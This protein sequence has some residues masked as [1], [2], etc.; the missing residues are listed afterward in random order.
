M[1]FTD[2]EKYSALR[3]KQ[4][5]VLGHNFTVLY[6]TEHKYFDKVYLFWDG[7]KEHYH[8]IHNVNS[9][10]NDIS[11]NSKW[12]LNCNKSY[13]VD[14]G[15]YSK[16]KCV[17]NTCYFCKEIFE[18]DELKEEHF[19]SPKWFNCEC[20]NCWCPNST[21]LEKHT[22]KCK[23]KSWRC[24]NCKKYI[25]KDHKEEHVCGEVYCSVCDIHHQ[26]KNHR[27]WIQPLEKKM[28][29]KRRYLCF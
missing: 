3:H 9:A 17:D 5:V 16:H 7:E 22:D 20:C 29:H 12:C 19:K 2:F 4:I 25:S 1:A 23:G 10:T 28:K 27:C 26:D 15:A 24:G 8:Y 21:C 14:S 6:E 18:T 11:R 13:R